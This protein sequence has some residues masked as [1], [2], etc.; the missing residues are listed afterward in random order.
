MNRKEKLLKI[1]D[2]YKIMPQL[3]YFQSEVF[4]LNE[5][6]IKNENI[7]HIAEELADVLVMLE[8]FKLYYNIKNE[9]IEK[10]MDYKIDRQIKR[11]EI[12]GERK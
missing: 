3:K 8:Q 5:A 11:I 1:I 4:E 10:I 2:T 7:E 9:D 6:I 12:G